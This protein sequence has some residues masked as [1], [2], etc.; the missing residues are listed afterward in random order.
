MDDDRRTDGRTDDRE[1][2]RDHNRSLEPL[3]PVSKKS[4]DMSTDLL[5]V[6]ICLHAVS[7][8]AFLCK[9]VSIF[10]RENVTSFPNYVT[11]TIW[12]LLA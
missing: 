9:H 8:K 6:P 10:Y 12:A 5:T 7:Q 2:T 3:A 11:T 1:T 4:L